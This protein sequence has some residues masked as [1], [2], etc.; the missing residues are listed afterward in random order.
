MAAVLPLRR[1]PGL[2]RIG[3]SARPL[4]A[5]RDPYRTAHSKPPFANARRVSTPPRTGR[6]CRDGV[7]QDCR[8]LGVERFTFDADIARSADRG[9]VDG[10]TLT[11][12]YR[13]LGLC[14]EGCRPARLCGVSLAPAG[15]V[16][17]SRP[18]FRLGEAHDV[19]S[20]RV[21]PPRSPIERQIPLCVR[22]PGL[23]WRAAPVRPSMRRVRT[24]WPECAAALI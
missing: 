5:L 13:P 16:L 7:P 6:N 2:M 12:H 22:R 1:E 19:R 18:R 3:A 14:P 9:G 11:G 4:P 15:P 10:A 8:R 20:W 24:K 17:L 23:L 21:Q